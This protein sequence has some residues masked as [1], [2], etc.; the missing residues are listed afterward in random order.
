MSLTFLSIILLFLCTSVGLQTANHE[1]RGRIIR[2]N[3]NDQLPSP[4]FRSRYSS[5][6]QIEVKLIPRFEIEPATEKGKHTLIRCVEITK[7][8]LEHAEHRDQR[9]R[10]GQTDFELGGNIFLCWPKPPE[11]VVSAQLRLCPPSQLN[12]SDSQKKGATKNKTQTSL[13]VA[14][15]I[16][17]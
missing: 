4:S 15:S 7:K 1:I 14:E 9:S 6:V 12:R 13:P 3:I 2:N 8:S 17:G 5:S 10:N 11:H 16:P